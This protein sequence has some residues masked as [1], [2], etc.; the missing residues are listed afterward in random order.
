M[1]LAT[2][3]QKTLIRTLM[4]E[5]IHYLNLKPDSPVIAGLT[6]LAAHGMIEVLL[7]CPPLDFETE[8]ESR[9]RHYEEIIANVK[10][11]PTMD[12]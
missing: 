5:K 8:L 12:R 11:H 2:I 7:S 1:K 10:T 3:K 6:R 4:T 9:A